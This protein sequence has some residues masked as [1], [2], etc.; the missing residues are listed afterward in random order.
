[1]SLK[2]PEGGWII[3]TPGVRSFGLGHVTPDAIDRGF[4]DLAEWLDQCPRGCEHLVDEP[5]C[6]L[7]L[8]KASGG[9]SDR[10]LTRIDSLQRLRALSQTDS[11]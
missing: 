8:R 11:Y 9:L 1:V 4:P 3:D 6:G 10:Q 5:D 2:L 7:N